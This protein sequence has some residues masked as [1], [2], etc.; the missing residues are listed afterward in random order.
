MTAMSF[1]VKK[2][3]PAPEEVTE[4]VRLWF[5]ASGLARE[6]R[7]SRDDI[8]AAVRRGELWW[9]VDSRGD[10][11]TNADDLEVGAGVGEEFQWLLDPSGL[12]GRSRSCRSGGA[13]SQE[14]GPCGRVPCLAQPTI[15]IESS[16]CYG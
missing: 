2:G 7:D 3:E 16:G 14:E 12:L 8:V 15:P 11:V 5:G 13:R 1:G 4:T 10:A 9:R 6:E